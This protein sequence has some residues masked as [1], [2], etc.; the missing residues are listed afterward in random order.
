MRTAYLGTSEFAEA[1]LR[2][3]A[4]SPHRPSLVVTPPDRRQGRG[5]KV[6][7]PPAAI[8]AQELGLE[9]LQAENVNEEAALERIR[10]ARPEAVVVCAFGQLIREPLLSEFPMLNVHP[11]LLPRWRGAAPIERAIMAG[12]PVTGVCVMRLTAGLDSGPVALREEVA[13]DPEEDFESLSARLAGLGGNLLVRA[14]DLQAEGALEF[15]EQG[16]DGVT[17]AEKIEPGE[18]RL[19][20]ARPA[21]E[22]ANRVRALTPHI[23][24]YIELPDGERLGVRRARAVAADLEPGRLGVDDG[25]LLLGCGEGAL[26]LEIV[27]PAGGKPMPA[28]AYL[29]GHPLPE[30]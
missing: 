17:Y 10:A 16:E 8:A 25:A 21:P 13:I 19:D 4:G 22:L 1:V 27:Q 7:P 15:T 18:R 6:K 11:S 28:D 24:A 9:L 3:L 14:L 29:R 2:R 30:R 20:P 23:G 26:R 12:D 5:R